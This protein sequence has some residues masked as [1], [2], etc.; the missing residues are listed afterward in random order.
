MPELYL[1]DLNVGD[2][3]TSKKYT[4]TREDIKAYAI[5]YDPQP[6]HLDDEAAKDT[7]FE[8]LAASGWHTASITMRLMVESIPIA[9]GLIGAGG[10]ISWPIPTRPND[11]L[12]V[13]A[14]VISIKPSRSKPNRGVVV[15]QVDTINQDNEYAQRFTCTMVAFHR[16]KDKS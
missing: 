16:N 5:Q 15:I 9:T 6:F 13:K 8:G 12:Q 14:E 11:T 4:V 2:K 7:F 1:E 3:W 10:H